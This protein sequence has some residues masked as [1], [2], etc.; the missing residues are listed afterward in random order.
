MEELT[1]EK[2]FATF[3]KIW[4]EIWVLIDKIMVAIF[5]ENYKKVEE[6]TK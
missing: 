4:A 6:E 5:G 3:E 1:M 2:Y